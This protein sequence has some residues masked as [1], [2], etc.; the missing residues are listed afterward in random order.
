MH[1]VSNDLLTG[2]AF[3]TKMSCMEANIPIQQDKQKRPLFILLLGMLASIV[4]VLLPAALL[5][6][7]AVWAYA[8]CRTKPV[9][10]VACGGVFLVLEMLLLGAFSGACLAVLAIGCAAALYYMQTNRIGNAYTVAAASGIAS[11][12]L[13]ALVCL[14][15]ILSGEGAFTAVLDV[16]D[17]SVAAFRAI[18]DSTGALPAENADAFYQSLDAYVKLLPTFIVPALC[19][20]GGVLGLSN[21]LFFRLFSRG[22][23]YSITPLRPFKY[24]SIPRDLTTGLIVML[25]GSLLMGLT[26]WDYAD[27]LSNTVNALVGMPLLLQGLCVLDFLLSRKA[28][29]RESTRRVLTYLVTGLLFVVLQTPLIMLGCF[30]QV[31]RFRMRAT[32]PPQM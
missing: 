15:G 27:A 25:V 16:L 17:E 10:L 7:P 2:C 23:A 32:S 26:G 1:T 28:D 8:M 13:Y 19:I 31:F 11:V 20:G 4:G 21:F 29:G 22:K 12:C 5:I 30:D 6:V 18:A 3:A 24:W 14:P 9:G